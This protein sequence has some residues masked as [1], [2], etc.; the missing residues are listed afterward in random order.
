[1]AWAPRTTAALL[2]LLIASAGVC[3][4]EQR[5]SLL[6]VLAA[7][8]RYDGKT[9][10]LIGYCSAE[11]E[12]VA[13]YLQADD[14]RNA[15]FPN[16]VWLDVDDLLY[17]GSKPVKGSCRVSGTYSATRKGHMSY[18]TGT[19]TK[20]QRYEKWPPPQKRGKP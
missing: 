5:P 11:F 3:A 19:L 4:Q 6:Q 13:I 9:V 10:A 14:S 2:T 1:M 8:E 20:V 15:H 7:P 12:N 17:A 18:F 16:G